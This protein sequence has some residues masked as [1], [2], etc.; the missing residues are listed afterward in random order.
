MSVRVLLSFTVLAIAGVLIHS[1]RSATASSV[2]PGVC[3]EGT[4][5]H[6]ALWLICVPVSGWNGD[7]VVWAHGY[8]AFNEPLDFYHLES[9]AGY[10]PDLVQQRGY[11]FATTSYRVNGLA[12]LEGVDDVRELVEV[13]PE[14]AGRTPERL[15]LT[16]ASEGGLVA[17]LINERYPQLFDSVLA[18]CGP[19]GS[20]S[21]QINYFGDFRVLFE[22]FFPG[23]LPGSPSSIPIGVISDWDKVYV[24]KIRDALANNRD[25]A[26]QLQRT[27]KMAVDLTRP[28]DSLVDGTVNLLWYNVFGT[29]DATTKLGGNPFGNTGRW[30]WA[31]KNDWRL[32]Q[33]ITRFS[34]DAKAVENLAKYE[35]SGKVTKPLITL[36]TFGD[37][38]V[39]YWHETRYLGKVQTA[40]EGSFVPI[41]S[42][43]YGHCSFG[44]LE[45]LAAFALLV[46]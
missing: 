9:E 2:V 41:P 30:Y 46:Q 37:E 31:S 7:L 36:H 26:W 20:F 13:F 6:G 42:P 8:V 44:E 43:R 3:E 33:Q 19:I 28:W 24:P 35:T 17:T 34:A 39:P 1:E 38:I 16:G 18:A 27:S 21:G 5:P 12:V 29:N 15:F 10:L 23:I 4:L 32:N 14:V 11:A 25:S 40:G 22:Y 45:I